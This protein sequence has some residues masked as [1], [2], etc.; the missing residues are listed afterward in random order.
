MGLAITSR[1]NPGAPGQLIISGQ[2]RAAAEAKQMVNAGVALPLW[3][4]AAAGKGWTYVGRWRPVRF[5]TGARAVKK[6][7]KSAP[8]RFVDEDP[9]PS[10]ILYLEPEG[11]VLVNPKQMGAG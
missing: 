7:R 5:D 2:P 9:P 3:L 1:K 10:G 8:D 11:E 4:R 6:A